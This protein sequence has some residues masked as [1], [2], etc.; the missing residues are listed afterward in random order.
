MNE[1]K[2]NELKNLSFRNKK[3]LMY[4]RVRVIFDGIEYPFL[5][6]G[7]GNKTIK[8]ELFVSYEDILKNKDEG[9]IE[10]KLYDKINT[11]YEDKRKEKIGNY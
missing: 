9:I 10:T 8:L 5:I 3:N 7:V 1:N 6:K 11:V 4:K 2:I